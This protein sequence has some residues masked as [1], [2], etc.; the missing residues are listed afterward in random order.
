VVARNS[1]TITGS[2]VYRT[3]IIVML[4]AAVAAQALHPDTGNRGASADSHRV[5]ANVRTA[6]QASE[7]IITET[8]YKSCAE[9]DAPMRRLQ[10]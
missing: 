10:A 8:A 5:L 1:S 6:S 9:V 7:P 4:I 2:L 3:P